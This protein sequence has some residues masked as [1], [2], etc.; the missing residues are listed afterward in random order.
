MKSSAPYA[1]VLG[2]SQEKANNTNETF[3][4]RELSKVRPV[5]VK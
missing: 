5:G 1:F 3:G 2:D 4:P